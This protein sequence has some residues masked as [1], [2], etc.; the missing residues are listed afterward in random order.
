MELN[1]EL[2]VKVGVV[3]GAAAVGAL[4][5]WVLVNWLQTLVVLAGACA[6]AYIAW[7]KVK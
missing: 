5:T 6:A 7:L 1:K 4:G 3:A 2:L